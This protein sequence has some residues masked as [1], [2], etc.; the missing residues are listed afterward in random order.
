MHNCKFYK[1]P[2]GAYQFR[3]FTNV[4]FDSEPVPKSKPDFVTTPFFD[5]DRGEYIRAPLL[6]SDEELEHRRS[7]SVRCSLSRSSRMI[8]LLALSYSEWK[9]FV[10]WTFDK[11]IIGNRYDYDNV[12]S[13]FEEYLIRYRIDHPGCHY[14]IVPELHKDGAYH[15][16]GLF[17]SSLPVTYAG[18]FNGYET[19]HV[20]F[21]GLGYTTATKVKSAVRVSHYISKYMTKSLAAVSSGRKRYF[22]TKSTLKAIEPSPLL[23]QIDL[24]KEFLSQEGIES[25]EKSVKFVNFIDVTLS[26]DIFNTY[27]YSFCVCSPFSFESG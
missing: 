9:W 18:I 6:P 12:Y 4:V 21:Y 24:F 1:N 15:F 13:H 2:D 10:T 16:H 20:E 26:E 11:E 7:E 23:I 3:L 25:Y 19:W 17:D 14:I 22:H 27:L 5:I 8:K